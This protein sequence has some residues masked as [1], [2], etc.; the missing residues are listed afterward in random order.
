MRGLMFAAA[1]SYD[2]RRGA[3]RSPGQADAL[4]FSCLSRRH[5]AGCIS[6]NDDRYF[7]I[8]GGPDKPRYVDA[9]PSAEHRC[10]LASDTGLHR[11][12]FSGHRH[13]DC[14]NR[15]AFRYDNQRSDYSAFLSSQDQSRHIEPVAAVDQAPDDHRAAFPRL[16]L[17]PDDQ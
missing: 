2:H 17:L 9:C 6:D 4:R 14:Y 11:R 15:G 3:E 5:C 8:I 16:S 7:D 13:G 12:L 10:G 1:I